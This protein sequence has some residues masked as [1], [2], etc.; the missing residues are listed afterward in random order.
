LDLPP[1]PDEIDGDTI[2]SE[3]G[4]TNLNDMLTGF[5]G[6]IEDESGGPV[7][8]E[9]L[10]RKSDHMELPTLS[11]RIRRAEINSVLSSFVS[12]KEDFRMKIH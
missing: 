5:S 7:C 1:E 11:K 3:R 6:P 2:L 4:S 10:K 8:T 9:S 12:E